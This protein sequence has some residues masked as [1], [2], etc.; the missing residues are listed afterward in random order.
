[1]LE[2]ILIPLD[3]STLAEAILGQ[4][5]KILFRQDSELVLVRAVTIPL[6]TEATTPELMESI[7]VQ[8]TWYLEEM[9]RKLRDQ[10]AR[11]RT[12]L[13]MGHPAEVILEVAREERATLI[14]MTTHG[15]TGL[16][17]WAFGSVTEKVLRASPIPVLA[18]RSFTAAGVPSSGEELKLK[19]ILIP[20]SDEDL[21]MKIVE[22][23]LEL[24]RLFGSSATLLH[25]CEGA[26]C[27]VPV[28][29]L[30]Q[31]FDRFR[32]AGLDAEP[33]MRQGD[34]AAQVLEAC[35]ESNADL[36]AMTTHGRAGLSRWLMG[37][38]TEKLL[39]AAPVPLLIV[40]PAAPKPAARE[41][42]AKERPPA[43]IRHR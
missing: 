22:P 31:A 33:L 10:G 23:A 34:P 3:G 24:A 20:V 42:P 27:A 15:R 11:V 12:V 37:S 21:S 18:T 40:R 38:V 28:P 13:R 8:A 2:T 14:A 17:H 35:R 16:S 26:A 1:M 43:P 4:V 32:E 29:P 9:A 7:Q 30:K 5:R 39:R 25:V 19:K 36:I 41:I 6:G